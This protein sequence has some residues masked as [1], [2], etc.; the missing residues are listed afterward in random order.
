MRAAVITK[1]GGV[2][3]AEEPLPL[4]GAGE[5]RVR[6]EGCGVCASSLPLWQGREWFT[7]PLQPG[8][9][10]H[11]GWG[12]V[13]DEGDGTSGFRRG[14]RVGFLSGRA[15]AEYDLARG[16]ELVRIP[17][18]LAGKS[19]PAEALGCTMNIFRRS[20]VE[21]GQHVVIIGAG[22][23][24]NALVQLSKAAGAPTVVVSRRESALE[25]ARR[26]GADETISMDDHARIVGRIRDL[27]GGRGAER[28]IECV[29]AQ[30]PLD[31]AGDVVAEGGRLVIAG[32]HQD[33]ARQ[34]NMQ[35][36]NWLGIDVINAHE[37]DPRRNIQGMQE[38]LAAVAAGLLDL[39]VL[40]THRYRLG[41]LG[42]ALDAVA[43]R[44]DGFIK[45]VVH[46]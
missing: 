5:V 23:L 42:A 16:G 14:E 28:V 35:R 33:G 34:V 44:P 10:G 15:F 43:E 37:R 3:I 25:L 27:T 7:Y 8:A 6:V 29:G 24:G 9:P 41:E 20:A 32:Y 17:D 11:E 13:D 2:A 40:L 45:G 26:C 22:F 21:P 31:L 12:E 4:P 39:D 46:P 36:W 30:W 18:E 19:V 1:A 38:G